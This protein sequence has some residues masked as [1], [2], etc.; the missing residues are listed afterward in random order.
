MIEHSIALKILSSL[1]S[2]L[3]WI[4]IAF[5]FSPTFDFVLLQVDQHVFITPVTRIVLD[6]IKIVLAVLIPLFVLIKFLID[7]IKIKKGK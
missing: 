5:G 7:F 3:M 1:G 2:G 4:A 6:E